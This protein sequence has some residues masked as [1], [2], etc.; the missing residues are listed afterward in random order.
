MESV[1][2][3]MGDMISGMEYIIEWLDTGKRPG[4]KRGIERRATYQRERPMDPLK[5]QA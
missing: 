3:S 4:N 5:L 1:I 2:K